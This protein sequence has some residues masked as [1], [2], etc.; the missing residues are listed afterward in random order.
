MA[1]RKNKQGGDSDDLNRW[2]D[3]VDSNASPDDVFWEEMERQ[4]LQNQLVADDTSTTTAT[5]DSSTVYD[6]APAPGTGSSIADIATGLEALSSRSTLAGSSTTTASVAAMDK[7]SAE[8]TLQEFSAFAVQD[9]W[10]DDDLVALY[11][12]N[13]EQDEFV[14]EQARPLEEQLEEWEQQQNDNDSSNNRWSMDNDEPWD[15]FG[16]ETDEDD[17]GDDDQDGGGALRVEPITGTL[18]FC[19]MLVCCC[20]LGCVIVIVLQDNA[21][22]HSMLDILFCCSQKKVC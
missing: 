17:T 4:R 10:L 3:D 6:T 19:D 14:S 21:C 8:A 1:K 22:L 15:H 5:P 13:A 20:S 11:N 2:Y 7:K 16:E 9:N 12:N 18:L